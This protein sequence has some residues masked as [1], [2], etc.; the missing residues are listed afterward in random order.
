MTGS[1]E[2]GAIGFA[3]KVLELLDEGRYT[4]TYKYAVLLALMD[5]CLE[6][7]TKNGGA[8]SSVT[9][10]QL[11]GAV[12]ELYWPHTVPFGKGPQ[13]VLLQNQPSRGGGQ[14]AIIEL[15]RRFRT[16]HGVAAATTV[17]RARRAEPGAG[18]GPPAGAPGPLPGRRRGALTGGTAKRTGRFRAFPVGLTDYERAFSPINTAGVTC[19]GG[20]PSAPP[21]GHPGG[22]LHT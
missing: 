5:L 16:K 4:A 15:I 8:P 12:L 7:S 1:E 2:R 10:R 20:C 11:A 19:I 21:E 9:T 18:V 14:A 22:H 17:G 13:R 3:E 6:Y